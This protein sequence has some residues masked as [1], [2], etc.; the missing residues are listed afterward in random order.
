MKLVAIHTKVLTRRLGMI[1]FR[2]HLHSLVVT[3]G[4]CE[5]SFEKDFKA[6]V[7]PRIGETLTIQE[8]AFDV[9]DI[10]HD[11][12]GNDGIIV[13]CDGCHI[14][15]IDIVL[16]DDGEPTGWEETSPSGDKDEFR[17]LFKGQFGYE[18]DSKF[19]G[20]TE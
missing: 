7:L 12:T 14:R 19:H 11:L 13:Y 20:K 5:W 3:T 15:Q 17:T 6:R 1:K 10:Y 9:T 4:D 18:F 2:V 8:V 16:D